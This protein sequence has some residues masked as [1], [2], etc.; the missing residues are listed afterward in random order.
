[1]EDEQELRRFEQEEVIPAYQ[2]SLANPMSA[3][4]IDEVRRNLKDAFESRY[5]AG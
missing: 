1:M 5:R 3:I 4:P 2:E